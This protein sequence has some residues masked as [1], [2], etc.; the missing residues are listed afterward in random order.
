MN[1]KINNI[2]FSTFKTKS[3]VIKNYIDILK[4][5]KK[6]DNK[7]IKPKLV[8]KADKKIIKSYNL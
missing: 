5:A 8:V 4:S 1:T 3:D 2:K 6:R 7:F